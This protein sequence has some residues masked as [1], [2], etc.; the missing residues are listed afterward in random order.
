MKSFWWRNIIID[1]VTYIFKNLDK[2]LSHM[3]PN[4]AISMKL[5]K[6]ML[7]LFF[8][9]KIHPTVYGP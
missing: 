9:K 6:K 7:S 8:A 2:I 3:I 4:S 5:E 1:D